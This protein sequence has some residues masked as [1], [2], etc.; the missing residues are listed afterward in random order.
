MRRVSCFLPSRSGRM[1]TAF[2]CTCAF[3]DP[4]KYGEHGP[5]C[6]SLLVMGVTGAGP[7]PL[8]M[9]DVRGKTLVGFVPI[10]RS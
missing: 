6:R 4:G 7:A 2:A 9:Q 5:P 10:L 8:T 1:L 3:L